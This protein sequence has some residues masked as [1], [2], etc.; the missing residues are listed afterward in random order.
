MGKLRIGH[1]PYAKP[2]HAKAHIMAKAARMRAE[3]FRNWK[4]CAELDVM[5]QNIRHGQQQA[6]IQNEVHRLDGMLLGL[7]PHHRM[8]YV[9]RREHLHSQLTPGSRATLNELTN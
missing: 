4:R 7:H 6:A 5:I 9:H 1:L 3:H 8:A 2:D